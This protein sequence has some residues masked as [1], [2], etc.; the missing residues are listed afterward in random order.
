MARSASSFKREK[1]RFKP[2][3]T[4]LVLCED[5]KSSKIYLEEAAI[6]FRANVKVK[7]AHCRKT[8]PKGIV[9]EAVRQK[10]HFDAVFCVIDRDAHP[11]FE[12][13]LRQADANG[14]TIIASYPCFEFWLILHYGYNTRPYTATGEKS[15]GD[16]VLE[17]LC[18]Q[19]GMETYQ[20]GG[21]TGLFGKLLGE[22]FD[23]ARVM[24]PRV[25]KAAQD[26]GNMNPSTALHTLIDKFEELAALKPAS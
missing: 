25:L 21:T 17:E 11:S 23:T 6:H 1:A 20:K 13:A 14:V 3:P 24:S 5:I 4:I 26:C 19:P 7:I 16:R 8:D 2:Q 15:A 10:K 9:T 12:E 22:P 18:G